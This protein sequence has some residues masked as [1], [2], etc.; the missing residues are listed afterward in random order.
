MLDLRR[1]ATMQIPPK[2]PNNIRYQPLNHLADK[3]TDE[4]LNKAVE[5][6]HL[7]NTITGR[8][9]KRALRSNNQKLVRKLFKRLQRELI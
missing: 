7:D 6:G 3:Q 4:I 8:R 5:L 1:I 2:R 9:I